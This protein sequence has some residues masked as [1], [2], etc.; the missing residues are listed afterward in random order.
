[1]T[2]TERNE[3]IRRRL[4]ELNELVEESEKGHGADAFLACAKAP[5]IAFCAFLGKIKKNQ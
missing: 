4:D 5:L 3:E 1:M 2:D